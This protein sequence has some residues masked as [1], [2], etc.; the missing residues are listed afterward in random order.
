MIA[1]EASIEDM[2]ALVG[3]WQRFMR[4]E[5]EAVP[6]ADPAA[7]QRNWS[8]RL[9]GQIQKGH[10]IIVKR[11]GEAVGF[12]GFIDVADRDWVPRG[13]AYVVDI[14]VVPGGRSTAAARLLFERFMDRARRDYDD[15]WTNTSLQNRRVQ[16]LLERTGFV[17]MTDFE[18]PG[19][20][21]Q[22]YLRKSLKD[23]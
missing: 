23:E 1:G 9:A 17:R 12:L 11:G 21:N 10:T 6:D 8:A 13:V 22:L 5:D 4:E 3:L 20:K 16:V 2:P 19:L 15:V 14:Y 7:V 18:I